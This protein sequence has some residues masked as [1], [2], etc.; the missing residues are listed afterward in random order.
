MP[1]TEY[2]L[3]KQMT[4]EFMVPAHQVRSPHDMDDMNEEKAEEIE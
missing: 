4:E 1:G 2:D 3:T